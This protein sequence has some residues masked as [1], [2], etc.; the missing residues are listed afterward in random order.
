MAPPA[1]AEQFGY[2]LFTARYG[3]VYTTRQLVQLF[4]RAFGSFVP[5]DDVWQDAQGH[6]LDPY[7][8]RIHPGGF[9]TMAEYRTD[10]A[11]HFAATREAFTKLDV[12][13]FT[14]GNTEGWVN[15][16]DGAAYPLCPGVAG[17][18]FD[19]AHHA[20]LNLDVA[21]V[22]RDMSEFITLLRGVNPGAR[23]ILTVSPVPVKATAL[24]RHV[25]VSSTFTKS[26]LRVAADEV[27]RK[28]EGVVYFPS[29]ELATGPQ[30]RGRYYA[31]DT[32][33]ITEEGLQSVMRLFLKHFA[34]HV[35]PQPVVEPE[36]SDEMRRHREHVAAMEKVV[37]AF[38]DEDVI[39]AEPAASA[40]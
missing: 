36:T 24:D 19:P 20:L 30:A 21:D 8:P 23:L 38:C 22:T 3:N 5:V 25:L 17:G 10:R 11:R 33:S 35:S 18:T 1:L 28:H 16:E 37:D 6:F 26:V 9:K 13:V 14:M 2:G 7:R 39:E 29:Y 4:K 15:R 31:E 40:I 27:V 32:R 12:L 34:G